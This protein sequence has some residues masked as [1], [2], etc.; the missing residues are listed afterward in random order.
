MEMKMNC[1]WSLWNPLGERMNSTYTDKRKTTY[2]YYLEP[3]CT[4]CRLL[5]LS[6]LEATV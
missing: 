6:L 3:G 4:I 2:L 5:L 1:H